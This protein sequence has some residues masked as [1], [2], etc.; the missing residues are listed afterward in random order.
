MTNAQ[1]DQ[2]QIGHGVAA[3]VKPLDWSD[4]KSRLQT[5]KAPID[6]SIRNYPGPIPGCD[7]Q[8]NYLLEERSKLSRELVRLEKCSQMP[9]TGSEKVMAIDAFIRSSEILRKPT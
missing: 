6:H 4:L 5:L 7:A 3:S 8:F 1:G 2:R 9:A